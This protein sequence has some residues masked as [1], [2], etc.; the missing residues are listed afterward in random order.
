MFAPQTTDTS[1]SSIE[2]SNLENP[3]RLPG[4]KLDHFRPFLRILYPLCVLMILYSQLSIHMIKY[5]SID[6]TPVE[7]FDEWIGVL[8]LATKWLFEEVRFFALF[9][10]LI[11][12]FIS[13]SNKSHFPTY[14]PY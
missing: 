3:I 1:L 8:N 4:V 6:Q 5:F 14:R 7:E 9:R 2:G 12:I 11:F 10:G 13:D